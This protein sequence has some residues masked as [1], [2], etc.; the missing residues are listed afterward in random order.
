MHRRLTLL[1]LIC[2]ILA[3]GCGSQ[4]S[5][6]TGS[7]AAAASRVVQVTDPR[8]PAIA[9]AADAA[10]LRDGDAA[11]AGRLLAQL[12]SG[13]APNVVLSPFSISDALAMTFAGARGETAQQIAH[14]LDFRL[15]ASQLHA[16]F[17]ALEQSLARVAGP[18]IALDTAN[19]LYGQSGMAFRAA[20]L[21]VLARYY[22]TGIR[23]VDFERA[24]EAAR[25]AIN[26]WVA[27]QTHGKIPELIAP[28]E[29]DPSTRLV[30]VNAIYM[31]A[32]W[33]SPFA[34]ASTYGATF[35]APSGSVSVPTMHQSATFGYLRA[36][37]YQAVELPYR[38]GRLAFD[39]LL[40]DSGDLAPLLAQIGR[41]GPLALLDGVAPRQLSLALPRL[42]L[43]THVNL[44]DALG[45]LGM[46]IA[47]EPGG[48]DL[49]GIA[50][51]PGELYIS[52][53]QHEAYIRVDE[54]GTTAAAATGVVV[55]ASAI[56]AP[57]LVVDVDRPFV[58]LIR[59]LRT[60]AV[61]FI[62]A[63]SNP[64]AGA[65]QG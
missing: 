60:G 36:P 65:G 34:H 58:F 7:E 44:T 63:I 17:N 38:G 11:F 47:F 30:L 13:S 8:A 39:V 14:A 2:L 43:R 31:K 29:V 53:V 48:A 51:R 41:A 23:T 10:T 37:G 19:A 57:P 59:D 15:P 1:A 25:L 24:P 55:G 52:A 12:A 62:G 54:S 35:H 50:G 22:G 56:E 6:S 49:S 9:P 5:A 64:A 21:S 45:T 61:L 42:L 3:A 28:G 27:A 18:G 32:A 16:A 46:P 33:A 26:A 40:P 4:G 20:F